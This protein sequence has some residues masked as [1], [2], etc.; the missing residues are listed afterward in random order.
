MPSVMRVVQQQQGEAQSSLSCEPTTSPASDPEAQRGQK[1]LGPSMLHPRSSSHSSEHARQ[2]ELQ[3]IPTSARS[4][5]DQ[6]A[7]SP[8]HTDQS[9]S[10]GYLRRWG[11]RFADYVRLTGMEWLFI[12]L[13]YA[14]S[15]ILYFW[16][17]MYRKSYRKI[18]MWYDPVK[19]AWY[20]PLSLSCHKKGW[21]DV[22]NSTMTAVVVLF[23]PLAIFLCIQLF[24]KSFWDAH[25]AKLGLI[26]ALALM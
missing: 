11:R 12:F 5:P 13:I 19:M 10:R 4:Q 25:Q 2:H 7:L 6:P 22:I 14:L 1:A 3:D 8:Q 20:G 16:V 9:R 21:P 18:P 17:P 24:T 23:V 15:G 26:K